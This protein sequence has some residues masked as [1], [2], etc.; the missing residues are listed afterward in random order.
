MIQAALSIRGFAIDS[1]DNFGDFGGTIPRTY[2]II[3]D[4]LFAVLLFKLK[5][6]FFCNLTPT[7]SE[8]KL[9]SKIQYGYVFH[10]PFEQIHIRR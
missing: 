9:D 8:V 1:L 4:L 2:V 10:L 5:L 6:L 7:Y 3:L